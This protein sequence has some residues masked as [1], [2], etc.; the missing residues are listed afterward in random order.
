[1]LSISTLVLRLLQITYWD[2]YRSLGIKSVAFSLTIKNVFF[3]QQLYSHNNRL[4]IFHIPGNNTFG[5][6]D[7]ADQHYLWSWEGAFFLPQWSEAWNKWFNAVFS[8]FLAEEELNSKQR[9]K[10]R[11]RFMNYFLKV[12]HLP[13]QSSETATTN[14]L[15]PGEI[16]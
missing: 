3:S 5:T 6:S 11:P 4:V 7:F 10:K 8:L 2:F 12:L 14:C 15:K 16:P 1:M 13:I 9:K